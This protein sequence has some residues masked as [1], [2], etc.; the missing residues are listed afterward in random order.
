MIRR[1]EHVYI[2]IF[3]SRYAARSKCSYLLISVSI[4]L[5]L[6]SLSRFFQAMLYLFKLEIRFSDMSQA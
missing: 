5:I 3:L 4:R 2:F 1:Y 6:M